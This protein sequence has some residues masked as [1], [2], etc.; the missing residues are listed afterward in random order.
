MTWSAN[1]SWQRSAF[2]MT[3]MVLLFSL[4]NSQ[5]ILTVSEFPMSWFEGVTITIKQFSSS[6]WDFIISLMYSDNSWFPTFLYV[7]PGRSIKVKLIKSGSDIFTWIGVSTIG[8]SS[9]YLESKSCVA[10]SI[11]TFVWEKSSLIKV[12]SSASPSIHTSTDA[13]S[14]HQSWRIIGHLVTQSVPVGNSTPEIDWSTEDFP[15]DWSPI[16]AID[17]K[18]ISIP[19]RIS[20]N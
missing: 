10:F 9:S 13:F 6:M 14:S 17:G 20:R 16:T 18:E 19:L 5:A 7:S 15:E 12:L 2:V 4:S 11:R 3:Q 8:Y 1:P